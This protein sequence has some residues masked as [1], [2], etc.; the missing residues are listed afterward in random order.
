MF[1]SLSSSEDRLLPPSGKRGGTAPFLGP[2]TAPDHEALPINCIQPTAIFIKAQVGNAEPRCLVDTGASV[3][4]IS[5]E[6]VV[7]PLRPCSLKARGISG[8]Q[9]QVLGMKELSV[10]INSLNVNHP[11]VVIGMRNTCI[12]GADFLKSGQIVVDVA[13]AK[14]SWPTGQVGLTVEATAPTVNKLSVLLESYSDVFVTHPHDSLGRT[15]EAEHCIDTGDS[16]PVKQRPYRIPVHLKGVVEN[17]ISDMLD[18]VIIQPSD[19]PWSSP[20]VLAPKKDGDYRFCVDFRRV[21]S[22]TKKDAHPIPR[23]DDI[24]DQ[25]GGATYFSTLDLASGYWQV[26]LKEE[27]REKTAFSVGP[28]HE[29]TVTSL[30]LLLFTRMLAT[31]AWALFFPRNEEGK[32]MWLRM[33]VGH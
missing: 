26:P 17:Q 22:V 20:I 15:T 30:Y 32:S 31:M 23:I 33:R 21:N 16:R 7:G 29:F 27:D 3:S 2:G 9:L 24:L 6:F 5:R 14:L 28:N 8:E 12:L 10:N 1:V 25:L 19:S 13:N 4:L 18:R 11:F